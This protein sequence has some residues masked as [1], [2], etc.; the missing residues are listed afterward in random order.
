LAGMAF[1]QAGSLKIGGIFAGAIAAS[2]LCLGLTAWGVLKLLRAL[3]P[4]RSLPVRQ[5]RANLLRPG[6]QT[7]PILLTLGIGGMLIL[8]LV[9][10]ERNLLWQLRSGAPETVPSFFF[11]DIQPD[12]KDRFAELLRPYDPRRESQLIPLVRSRLDRI[13]QEPVAALYREDQPNSWYFS[14]EYVLT[15]LDDLPEGNGIIRGRWWNGR[16]SGPGGRGLPEISVEEEAASHLGVDV[17]STMTFDIQGIT[18][19]AKVASLRRVDWSGMTPN[20][21]IIFEPGGLDSFPVSYVSAIHVPPE[22][23][24]PLQQSVVDRFPN[25]TVIPVRGVLESV[26]AIL[27]RIGLVIRFMAVFSMLTGLTVLIGALAA[28]RY[29]RLRESA[30]LKVLGA[31]RSLI[32]RSFAVEYTIL[33]TA[34]G[35]ISAALATMVDFIVIRYVMETPWSFQPGILLL[36]VLSMVV[37]TIGVGFL[38]TYRILGKRPLPVL[39]GE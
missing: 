28:T 38:S 39:R 33:G 37:I 4:S 9:L 36:G 32:A 27:D 17:G 8:T 29:Q 25:V 12:Q 34:A 13:D 35:L 1:Y 31:T 15:F 22:D 23:E 11:I 19:S 6:N 7:V 26:A 10:V 18:V 30:I 20:F 21:F 24:I 5:G 3:P 14:R 16:R 2:L